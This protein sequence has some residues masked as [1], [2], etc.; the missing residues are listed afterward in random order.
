MHSSAIPGQ[1][2][3]LQIL[4]LLDQEPVLML[5]GSADG[6]G[7]RWTLSGQEIPPAIAGFLMES[8]YLAETGKTDLGAR[9][10]TL[11]EEGRIFRT[12]GLA[13]WATL[14]WLEKLKITLLG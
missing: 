7:T 3:T 5:A 2:Q 13:W 8:G 12:N 11:T 9:I 10:L 6:F 14:S 1:A 4:R